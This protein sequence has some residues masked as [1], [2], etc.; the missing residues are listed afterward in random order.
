MGKGGIEMNAWQKVILWSVIIIFGVPSVVVL[1]L[2]ILMFGLG[3]V[4][5]WH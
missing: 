3:Y 5:T 4:V 2:G 1:I